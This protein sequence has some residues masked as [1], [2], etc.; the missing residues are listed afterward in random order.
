MLISRIFK[1]SFRQKGRQKQDQIRRQTDMIQHVSRQYVSE[2]T[3]K[4]VKCFVISRNFFWSLHTSK[5]NVFFV[6]KNVTDNETEEVFRLKKSLDLI[7]QYLNWSLNRPKKLLCQLCRFF[8]ERLI[9][10]KSALKW[11]N[12][13]MFWSP[14]I[15]LSKQIIG[16]QNIR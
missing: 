11:H 13:R 7:Q 2:K 4:N 14:I 5:L 6:K 16:D 12:Y 9:A 10:R 15:V 3:A 8:F 1:W